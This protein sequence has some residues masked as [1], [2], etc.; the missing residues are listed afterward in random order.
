MKAFHIVPGE[1]RITAV[2]LPPPVPGP[3]QVLVR[4]R[5]A[6]LNYLDLLIRDGKFGD[7]PSE[8]LVPMTDG[9]GEIVKAGEGCSRWREGDRVL[10]TFF[11]NWVAGPLPDDGRADLPGGS[12]D[13]ML[14]EYVVFDEGALVRCPAHLSMEE[15]STLPCAAVTAWDAL[16]AG[17]P[18]FPGQ[19]V[20]TQGS[21]GVSLFVLQLARAAGARVIATTSTET[22]AERLRALGAHAT[23]L[24]RNNP[25]WAREVTALTDGAGVDH[26]VEIGGAGTL[27]QSVRAAAIGAEIAMVGVLEQASQVDASLFMQQVTTIRRISVGSRASFEALNRAL[28]VNM[29]H[30]VIDHVFPFEEASQAYAHLSSQGHV[31]KIVISIA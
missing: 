29:I 10:G 31:G 24:Y 11:P 22:K 18:L 9:A 2:D 13:G 26:V 6:S 28:E 12:R 19:T 20:L 21:G 7:L 23:V 15:G 17:K 25:D 4:M 30:P 3:G 8:G 5:A 16:F 1:S 14:R 27:A